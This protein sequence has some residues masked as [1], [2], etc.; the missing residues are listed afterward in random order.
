MNTARLG[1]Q[2]NSQR[3][4][5]DY[6]KN[7]AWQQY[8]AGAPLQAAGAEQNIYGTATGEVNSSDS[9]LTQLGTASYGPWN[10]L[11]QGIGGAASGALGGAFS[12]GGALNKG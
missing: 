10:A 4:A 6:Q 12:K 3:A 11:I 2:L 5:E 8:L 1:T 9:A 7:L